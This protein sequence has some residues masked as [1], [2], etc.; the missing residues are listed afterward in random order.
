MPRALYVIEIIGTLVSI[1]LTVLALQARRQLAQITDAAADA[2][3]ADAGS[4][5]QRKLLTVAM[6]MVGLGVIVFATLSAMGK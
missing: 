5:W 3:P 6:L 4:N 1:P 2:A